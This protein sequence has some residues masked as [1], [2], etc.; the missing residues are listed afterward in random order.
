MLNYYL[1]LVTILDWATLALWEIRK[2]NEGKCLS[3]RMA[4]VVGNKRKSKP[5]HQS[6]Q[7]GFKSQTNRE[8]RQLRSTLVTRKGFNKQGREEG[9]V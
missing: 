1:I 6:T 2:D 8:R 5:P 9:K 7:Q 3:S 4:E